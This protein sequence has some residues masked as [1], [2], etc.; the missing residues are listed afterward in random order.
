MRELK[1]GSKGTA[2]SSLLAVAPLAALVDY[3]VEASAPYP[4]AQP[5]EVKLRADNSMDQ[6][7]VDLPE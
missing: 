3:F 5:E 6:V 7:R 1:P 4:S 2:D